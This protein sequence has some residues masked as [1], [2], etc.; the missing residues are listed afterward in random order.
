MI[1]FNGV[2]VGLRSSESAAPV[3][4][5]RLYMSVRADMFRILVGMVSSTVGGTVAVVGVVLPDGLCPA[6]GILSVGVRF[7]GVGVWHGSWSRFQDGIDRWNGTVCSVGC[8]KVLSDRWSQWIDPWSRAVGI[9][10]SHG[11]HV[12]CRSTVV[13][14]DRIS[15]C[16][17][18]STD[19]WSG[20]HAW[21]RWMWS[22]WTGLTRC[23]SPW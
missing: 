12:Q 11:G 21:D 4:V 14:I 8:R 19:R 9:C 22:V 15:R 6:T 16:C 18:C 20:S 5:D 23:G 10:V 17:R 13:C 1:F 2:G 3:G 7:C